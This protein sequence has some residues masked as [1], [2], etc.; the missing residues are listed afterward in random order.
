MVVKSEPTD[1]ESNV[2]EPGRSG[3]EL[4]D[5]E[6]HSGTSSQNESQSSEKENVKPSILVS[7]KKKRAKRRRANVSFGVEIN[8]LDDTLTNKQKRE[9]QIKRRRELVLELLTSER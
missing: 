1:D 5:E 6:G 4:T 9:L 3:T 7:P 8:I 2:D